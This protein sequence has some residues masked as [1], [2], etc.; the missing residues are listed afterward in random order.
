MHSE[1]LGVVTKLGGMVS[2]FT[3]L[4]WIISFLIPKCGCM[5]YFPFVVRFA[6]SLVNDE[7][8]VEEEEPEQGPNKNFGVLYLALVTVI[9]Y[10]ST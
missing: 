4:S 10:T 7:E 8:D 9:L 6:Y 1:I 3:R 5:L 2:N